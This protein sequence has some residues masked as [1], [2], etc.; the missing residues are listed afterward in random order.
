MLKLATFQAIAEEKLEAARPALE[1]AEAALNTI[2]PADI[3]T[4]RK[5][6]K[7]PHLI[8]RIMDCVLLLFQRKLEATQQDP[9]KACIKPS[10]TESL[11]V[12][13]ILLRKSSFFYLGIDYATIVSRNFQSTETFSH[14]KASE[15]PTWNESRK[16][17]LALNGG[18]KENHLSWSQFA[19]FSANI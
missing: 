5:L 10:W 9:E 16:V 11:K 2:K 17:R 14:E 1:E 18:T 8:M 15:I 7:P 12:R 13:F 19:V 4:V 3:A 6:G